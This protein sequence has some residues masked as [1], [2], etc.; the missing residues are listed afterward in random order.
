MY[1]YQTGLLVFFFINA[2]SALI[3]PRTNCIQTNYKMDKYSGGQLLTHNTKERYG[4]P[5][6][7]L[8][9]T[10]TMP[11]MENAYISYDNSYLQQ[12]QSE[13]QHTNP[14]RE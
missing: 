11:L 1:K 3:N 10:R 4:K 12:V 5:F 6:K 14:K 8:K 13:N 2:H 7:I 9:F